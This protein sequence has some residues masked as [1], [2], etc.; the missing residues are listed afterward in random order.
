MRL[1]VI[2]NFAFKNT[3]EFSKTVSISFERTQYW[4]LQIRNPVG[5]INIF[6]HC[7]IKFRH[8][9]VQA[10]EKAI[11]YLVVALSLW[12]RISLSP[13][14]VVCLEVSKVSRGHSDGHPDR[15]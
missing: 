1:N 10:V 7:T 6:P 14:V 8:C 2:H 15:S 13:V 9:I 12:V 3:F 11:A 5:T 4:T